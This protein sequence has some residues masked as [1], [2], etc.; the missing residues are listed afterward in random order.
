[1]LNNIEYMCSLV[2][3]L[4]KILSIRKLDLNIDTILSVDKYTLYIRN[5]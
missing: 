3:D 4:E 2:L 1:M 5:L